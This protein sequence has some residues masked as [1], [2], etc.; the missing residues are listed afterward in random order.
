MPCER[1]AGWEFHFFVLHTD[2]ERCNCEKLEL[3]NSMCAFWKHHIDVVLGEEVRLSTES[4]AA[5]H[6]LEPVQKFESMPVFYQA[7]L[8]HT[9]T[10]WHN[11]IYSLVLRVQYFSQV[12]L[13]QRII[14]RQSAL[15]LLHA[16]QVVIFKD[17]VRKR[18][19]F[20]MLTWLICLI[21]RI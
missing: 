14:K 18:Y 11:W 16:Y 21:K 7:V 17:A 19:F 8:N 3:S 6:L 2:V 10:V 15:R 5:A 13:L 20:L 9:Q 4:D 12:D 1:I